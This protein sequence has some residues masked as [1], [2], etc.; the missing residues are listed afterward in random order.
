MESL[1]IE[2]S[3]YVWCHDHRRWEK[4]SDTAPA[5]AQDQKQG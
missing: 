4:L 2:G 5:A 3:T 1:T